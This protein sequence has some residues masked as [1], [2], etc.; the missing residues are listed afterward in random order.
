MA[1]YTSETCG[2]V[3]VS[4]YVDTGCTTDY[5]QSEIKYVVDAW[6]RDNASEAIEARL[7]T[8]DE[9]IDLGYEWGSTGVSSEGW[10]RS[11][12]VPTW[13]Y[14]S[15]YRYWTIS[16]YNDSTFYVWIVREDGSFT[17]TEVTSNSDLGDPDEVVRPVIVLSKS[18]L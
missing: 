16:P 2:Y 10:I 11:E 6:K 12:N 1:Y 5:T 7:I 3:T 18:V 13:L 9:A 8:I 4:D 14:N 15:N 17:T